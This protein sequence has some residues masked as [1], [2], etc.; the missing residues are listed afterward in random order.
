MFIGFLDKRFEKDFDSEFVQ[1][2]KDVLDLKYMLDMKIKIDNNETTYESCI[3]EIER[4][5]IVL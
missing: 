2:V 3:E 4:K 5:A 1:E